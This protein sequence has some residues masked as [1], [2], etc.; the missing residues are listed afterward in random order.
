MYIHTF[1]WKI[2]CVSVGKQVCLNI[3][4]TVRLIKRERGVTHLCIFKLSAETLYGHE[5][6][7]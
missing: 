7:I 5:N 6:L 1:T 4:R 2:V 3:F